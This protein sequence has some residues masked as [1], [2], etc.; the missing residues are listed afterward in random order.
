[1]R[2]QQSSILKMLATNFQSMERLTQNDSTRS[3][4]IKRLDK[5]V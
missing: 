5:Q 2:N 1:M 3:T 4:E